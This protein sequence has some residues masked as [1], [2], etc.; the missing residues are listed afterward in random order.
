MQK[1]NILDGTKGTQDETEEGI[2]LGSR[3]VTDETNALLKDPAKIT[4]LPY[5]KKFD[6][7]KDVPSIVGK[8]AGHQ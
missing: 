5:Q 4:S 7:G 8:E 6:F 2:I 3:Y 1:N